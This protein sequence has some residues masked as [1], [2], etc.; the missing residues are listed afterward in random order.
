MVRATHI[1]T[2]GNQLKVYYEDGHVDLAVPTQ[3]HIWLVNSTPGS[4]G[5]GTG[6]YSW[7]YSLDYITSEFG[8]R[9]SGFHEGMDWSGGPAVL[10]EP[11]PAIGDGIIE[12]AGG[13]GGT[14][15]GNHVIIHHGTFD[16]YDWKSVYGHMQ[17]LP[18]VTT[19]NPV[20]KGATIGAVNNTGSSYGS[21]LHMETHR[22]AVGGSIIW[23]NGNPSWGAT[24]T[25]VNPRDFMSLYGDGSVIIP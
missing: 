9:G 20:L 2:Y 25:A 6:D 12:Y 15:F 24:R 22:C 14:G 16:G 8:P 23:A 11:I 5:G 18:P 17:N 1:E 10:G 3:G 7:P 19:G 4:G 13:A 21:H